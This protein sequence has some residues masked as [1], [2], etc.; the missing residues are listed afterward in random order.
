VGVTWAAPGRVNLIGEHTDY[1]DGFVLPIAL[2]CRTTAAVTPREDGRLRV[3]S[4]QRPG[5]QVEVA[6]ADLRPG[7]DRAGGWAGYVLG[8]AWALRE[9]GHPAARGADVAVDG[10][11]PEGAGLSSSADDHE[12]AVD[13][14]VRRPR[15]TRRPRRAGLPAGSPRSARC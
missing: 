3:R 11:V 8:V 5:E 14:G 2:P 12:D 10:R 9:A 7:D 1:N 13:R 15:S 4:V 6:V